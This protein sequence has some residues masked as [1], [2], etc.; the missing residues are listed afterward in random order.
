MNSTRHDSILRRAL[1]LVG[2]LGV[3]LLGVGLPAAAQE[4]IDPAEPVAL[5]KPARRRSRRNQKR[6]GRIGI[7]A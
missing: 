6:T 2:L 5:V 4:A 1:P 3:G 7:G